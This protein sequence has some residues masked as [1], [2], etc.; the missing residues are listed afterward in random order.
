[1]STPSRLFESLQLGPVR[2]AHRII[3]A[4]LTRYRASDNHVPL[5]YVAE[6]YTQR[7]CVPGTLIITEATLISEK[8]GGYDNVPTLATEEALN[9]WKSVVKAIHDRGC[10]VFC[11]LWALGR[12][13]HPSVLAREKERGARNLGLVSSSAVPYADGQPNPRELTE[14]EIQDFIHDHAAAAR[15]AVE[16][17]GFDGVEIHGANGYLVDQFTQEVS[18]QRTDRWGGSI[19]N[20]SRFA[21]EVAKAVAD[22]VGPERVGIRLSPWSTFQGMG[23]KDPRPQ[24]ADLIKRLSALGLEYLHLTESRFNGNADVEPSGHLDFAIDAWTAER[25]SAILLLAGGYNPD[26]ARHDV[27]EEYKDKQ[28]CISFGRF[29]ISN[30][31]L[32]FRVKE[33]IPFAHYDRSSFYTPKKTEGY[34]DYPFSEDWER[35]KADP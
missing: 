5:P 12:V 1:M 23:L 18:N 3:M 2:L 22:A 21:V 8:A 15:A 28:V 19:E 20:R 10:F 25:P 35:W 11:Q 27:D 29:F 9:S 24:F 31:D 6:Y 17:A 4:P 14:A 33:N 26:T 30:P 16:V 13:G 32:V 34:T 7:S